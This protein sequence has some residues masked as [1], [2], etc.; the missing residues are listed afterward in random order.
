MGSVL[1]GIAAR[2]P[3]FSDTPTQNIPTLIRGMYSRGV[4]YVGCMGPSFVVGLAT[5]GV[6]ASG[7]GPQ[8]YWLS[9]FC[10]THAEA[11][12]PWSQ[13]PG[14]LVGGSRMAGA[15]CLVGA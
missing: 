14:Q 15:D 3:L 10:F 2:Y 12:R 6:L 5:V 11:A 1:W 8:P 13:V 4:P 7:A 9:D